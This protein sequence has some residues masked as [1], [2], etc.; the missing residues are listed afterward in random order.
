MKRITCLVL[1]LFLL[2]GFSYAGLYPSREYKKTP[3]DYN[4]NYEE[5]TITTEDGVNLK[6]WYF[7]PMGPKSKKLIIISDD[8]AGNMSDNIELVSKFLSLE[9]QVTTYDYRGYGQSDDYDVDSKQF[10]YPDFVKDLMGVIDYTRKFH[11]VQ[12][13]DLFGIGIGAG[14]SL[15]IGANRTEI[16]RI[17]A[18]APYISFQTRQKQ[19]KDKKDIAV[20]MPT[21]YNK[22]YMEPIYALAEKGSHL[23]GILYVAG[24]NDVILGPDDLKPLVKLKKKKSKVYKVK[25]A[26]NAENYT[27]DKEAYFDQIKTFL[28]TTK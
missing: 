9:Y 6:G 24:E 8:G 17:I 1:S 21:V 4:M 19:L 11:N 26:T 16:R 28:T 13:F 15:A 22:Y 18:D 25:G 5:I 12:N 3:K 23:Y 14:L 20:E 10:V 27:S 7:K 2:S